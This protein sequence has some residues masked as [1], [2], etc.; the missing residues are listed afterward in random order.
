MT[1]L[2]ALPSDVV[3]RSTA[4]VAVDLE[5]EQHALVFARA[6][7]SRLAEPGDRVAGAL[8]ASLGPVEALN[9]VLDHHLTGQS[10]PGVHHER[11]VTP[12]TAEQ[13]QRWST[14]LDSTQSL[15]DLRSARRLGMHLLVPESPAWPAQLDALGH[16]APL[17]LWVRGDHTLLRSQSLAIV[18]ARAATAYGEHVTAEI[19]SRVGARNVSIVSGGAY[20][21]DGVAH[22]TSLATETS[23]IAILAG[24]ADRLYPSG[25]SSMLTT[26][27]ERGL[28]CAEQP[29]GS[30]PTKWRFLQ[31]NRL[32]AALSQATIV[33]EAGYRSGSLNTA[34]HALEIGRP[35][36]AV[37]GPV[38]SAAS[39]GCHRL[40]REYDA[41][42]IRNGDDAL[43]LMGELSD[44]PSGPVAAEA[45]ALFTRVLDAI[46]LRRSMPVHDIALH[47]GTA[48]RE[49]RDALTEL[50]LNGLVGQ[51]A[52]GWRRLGSTKTPAS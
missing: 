29:P 11:D 34:A 21:I 19:V 42:C 36:G 20:G 49:T 26:I 37:P 5:Q 48:L 52:E 14:R 51:S 50:E 46:P 39:A 7:W 32:I 13:M 24:G 38:T 44:E 25:H 18:G 8:V 27:A 16:H 45:S 9:F 3:R 41:V 43:E 6:V 33:C 12:E 35:L 30:S 31:R 1:T 2:F 47:A 17:A 10:R 23:T 4:E 15:T 22:R 40:L 28:L